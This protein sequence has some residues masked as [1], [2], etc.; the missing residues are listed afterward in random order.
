MR[1]VGSCC[2]CCYCCCV[3]CFISSRNVDEEGRRYSEWLD[4]YAEFALLRLQSFAPELSELAAVHG[5]TPHEEAS[6]SLEKVRARGRSGV[7]GEEGGALNAT[8]VTV[9]LWWPASSSCLL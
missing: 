1:D 4:D 3:V 5:E 7:G 6:R 2:C 8:G 9:W